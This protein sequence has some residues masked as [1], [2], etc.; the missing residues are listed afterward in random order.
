ML[1]DQNKLLGKALPCSP[2]P[3]YRQTRPRDVAA[4]GSTQV[5]YQG[6]DVV[7]LHK[8]FGRLVSQ[9]HVGD[10]L[11]LGHV[12]DAC[13]VVKLVANQ[14][15][16][17][18]PCTRGVLM[19]GMRHTTCDGGQSNIPA[20]GNHHRN[21]PGQ[22]ALHVTPVSATSSATVLVNL[23]MYVENNRLG[24]ALR[25]TRPRRALLRCTPTCTGLLPAH[26]LIPC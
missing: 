12:A 5:R 17:R 10:D 18:I 15:G 22:I 25:H 2:P 19:E 9:Q 23:D 4:V 11:L 6:P 13:S 16:E 24:V 20:I 14:V 7:G 26:A 8:A 1:N 3:I 21:V